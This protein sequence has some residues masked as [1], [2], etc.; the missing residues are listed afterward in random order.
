MS[1]SPQAP[2]SGCRSCVKVGKA[3]DV[4]PK[5][6]EEF[7]GVLE[8]VFLGRNILLNEPSLISFLLVGKK[9]FF[10]F[11][12]VTSAQKGRELV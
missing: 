8:R 1:F 5:L 9:T 10:F 11:P 3:E 4:L 6:L 12:F 7:L 2:F